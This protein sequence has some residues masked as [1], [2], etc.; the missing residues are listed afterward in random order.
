[1]STA[2]APLRRFDDH[3]VHRRRTI[4]S[5]GCAVV[6]TVGVVTAFIGLPVSADPAPTVGAGGTTESTTASAVET[7]AQTT[8]ESAPQTAPRTTPPSEAETTADVPTQ[9]AAAAVAAG[10]AIPA[11]I[12]TAA[13]EPAIDPALVAE[14]RR[15]AIGRSVVET[16]ATKLGAPYVYSAG[17]PNAFDCSGFVRWVWL[18]FGVS[19]PHNSVAMWNAV[20]HIPL[21]QLQ[22]GDI[23]F[24][25]VGGPP[26]HVAIYVGDGVMIHAPSTGGVVRYDRV[27]W[28]TGATV[29]A[30]RVVVPS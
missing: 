16:G 17:G 22:A 23:V 26:A 20:E 9:V 13:V 27:G 24:D 3:S 21:D 18:Q 10:S 25:S 28:W 19:L 11:S 30:G 4:A 1:M 14:I 2:S 7:A 5:I 15:Q 29:T 8:I 6:L 12:G